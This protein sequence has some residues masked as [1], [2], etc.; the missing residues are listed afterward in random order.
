IT[1]RQSMEDLNIVG[2]YRADSLFS[3]FN[4]TKTGGGERLLDDMFHHPLTDPKLINQ[5]SERFL[6]FQK[7]RLTFPV[8]SGVFSEMENY[9]H[10]GG[11]RTFFGSAIQILRLQALKAIGLRTEFELLIKGLSCTA[12]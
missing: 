4:Q 5:R 7:K 1:D 11:S 12:I 3:I 6:Y 2:K 10:S 9:L 8:D